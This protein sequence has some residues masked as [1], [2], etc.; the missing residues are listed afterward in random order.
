MSLFVQIYAN[1]VSLPK[2]SGV[3][4]TVITFNI[5]LQFISQ[6]VFSRVHVLHKNASMHWRLIVLQ[7]IS[8]KWENIFWLIRPGFEFQKNTAKIKFIFKDLEKG[9]NRKTRIRK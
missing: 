2:R 8:S 1:S 6:K 4:G 5:D 7:Q 3:V 9:K